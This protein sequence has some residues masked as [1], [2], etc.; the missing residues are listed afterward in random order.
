MTDFRGCKSLKLQ[1]LSLGVKTDLLPRPL[2]FGSKG[3]LHCI[4]FVFTA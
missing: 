1:F 2:Y 3:G 4:H